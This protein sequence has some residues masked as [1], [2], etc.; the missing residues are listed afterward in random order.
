MFEYLVE[1]ILF[2]EGCQKKLNELGQKGWELV[3]FQQN[4]FIFKRQVPAQ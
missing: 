1:G 4:T 2:G 3:N